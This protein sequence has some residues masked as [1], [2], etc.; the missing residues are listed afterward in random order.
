MFSHHDTKQE[1]TLTGLLNNFGRFFLGFEKSLNALRLLSR[2]GKIDEPM[3]PL[4]YR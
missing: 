4:S 1:F 3:S 2:L